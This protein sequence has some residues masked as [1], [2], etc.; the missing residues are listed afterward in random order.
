MSS[1]KTEIEALK[2]KIRACDEAYYNANQPLIT[3]A[4]YDLLFRRLLRLEGER[5]D[6][7]TKDSPTQKVGIAP[8]SGFAEVRHR[9]PMFSLSNCFSMEELVQFE[10]RIL[11]MLGV[12]LP[13]AINENKEDL[14]LFDGEGSALIGTKPQGKEAES[15]GRAATTAHSASVESQVDKPEA[16]VYACEPKIDGVAVNLMYEKGELIC[17]ATRGDGF[18]GEDITHNIVAIADI[19]PRL[20]GNDPPASVEI[21]GEIYI[22]KKDFAELNAMLRRHAKEAGREEKL[23]V[24]P[25]NAAAGALRSLHPRTAA[26]RRLR[27]FAHGIGEITG[28]QNQQSHARQMRQFQRW[29]IPSLP[30]LASRN[31]VDQIENYYQQILAK[32]NSLDYEI[33]GIVIKV[34]AYA[35]QQRLGYV[36]RAPRW[37]LAYKFPAEERSTKLLGVEF[38]IGRTGAVTPIARLEPVYVG[39]VTVANATLHNMDEIKRLDLRRGDQV[40][41]RR[42]GDVIPQVVAVQTE[43]RA[44]KTSRIRPPRLCPSCR[45]RLVNEEEMVVLRCPNEWQ[46]LQQAQQ[47]IKHFVSRNA[48]DIEGFGTVLVEELMKRKLVRRPQDIYGLEKGVLIELERYADKSVDNLLAAIDKSKKTTLARFIYALGIREVGQATAAALARYY[49]NLDDLM[50]ADVEALQE[51]EDVGPKVAQQISGFLADAENATMIASLRAAGLSWPTQALPQMDSFF[52]GKKVVLTGSLES[53]TRDQ[54]RDRLVAVGARVQTKVSSQTD[55]LIVGKNPG[56]KLSDAQRLGIV[57]L[58]EQNALS[59]LASP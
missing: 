2:R 16:L 56:S 39:G 50:V 36:S 38:Q 12:S 27:F 9:Q 53:M 54:L 44:T 19:P 51:I 41:I 59:H 49:G 10:R 57:I 55:H 6:L 43:L 5:P 18:T 29:G 31:G 26:A 34:D 25:R 35:L 42:A 48:M 37:A 17:A 15:N 58:N 45:A 22:G 24:N 47:R 28:A 7:I 20:R 1:T 21:R 52:A 23:F 46:C 13:P 40:I 33:D 14:G 30:D 11:K 8:S 3:D 4:E 32:R